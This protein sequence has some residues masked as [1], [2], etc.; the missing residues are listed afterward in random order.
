MFLYY[1]TTGKLSFEKIKAFADNKDYEIPIGKYTT[2]PYQIITNLAIVLF[3]FWVTA[4]LTEV[5][6]KRISGFKKIKT[7]N[8]AIII[9]M[10]HLVIY[11][12]AFIVGLY[13]L[14][15]N[16]TTLAVF[17]GALGI[18]L[19][20]GLQKI[21]SNF[22]SGLI[23]LFEKS[24]LQEDLIEMED[25][26]FGFVRKARARFTLVETHDGKEI[27]IPN[28]D[29]ITSRVVNWTHSNKRGRIELAV[30]VGYGS[31]I[32]QV[33]E[34]I[35]EAAR[36]HPRCLKK[37]PHEPKCHLRGFGDN[38]VDFI[39]HFWVGDIT[40]GRWEPD[41]E[42]LFAIWHQFKKHGIEIPFPQRDL[43]IKNPEALNLANNGD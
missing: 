39:L 19:G 38:S 43:H 27:M 7:S 3:I 36:S 5:V 1:F 13:L 10:L 33:K 12:I 11:F 28:E 20:F 6:D 2:S 15:I 8:R 9:K 14:G 35:L 24:I 31:D 34:L 25:G 16:L 4:I 26:T 18:G 32:E 41:S 22:I 21:S 37:E 17:S 23:L 40:V 29:F 30:G 42:V